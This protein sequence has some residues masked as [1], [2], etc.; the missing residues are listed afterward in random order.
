V[1]DTGLMSLDHAP[2]INHPLESHM[3]TWPMMLRDPIRSRCTSI[4]WHGHQIHYR[5]VFFRYRLCMLRRR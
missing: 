1:Q 3:V 2:I 4:H 5:H